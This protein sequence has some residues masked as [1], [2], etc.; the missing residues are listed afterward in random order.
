MHVLDVLLQVLRV[1]HRYQTDAAGHADLVPVQ[2][3]YVHLQLELVL[4][5]VAAEVADIGVGVVL[6]VLAVG[7]EV[8]LG[9]EELATVVELAGQVRVEHVVHAVVR[10]D[11]ELGRDGLLAEVAL[12][13]AVVVLDVLLQARAVLEDALAGATAGQKGTGV[14]AVVLAA[15]HVTTEEVPAAGCGL[16]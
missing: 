12:V 10:H 5:G 15:L 16:F 7:L 4:D 14:L 2:A 11:A 6:V 3:Q 13:R 9:A 8:L 1:L